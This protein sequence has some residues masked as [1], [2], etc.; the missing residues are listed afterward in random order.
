MSLLQCR[1]LSG[2]RHLSVFGACKTA[3]PI[4]KASLYSRGTCTVRCEN[5]CKTPAEPQ[6]LASHNAAHSSHEAMNSRTPVLI[7]YRYRI[8]IITKYIVHSLQVQNHYR[9]RNS[10]A[11][12][13]W[14]SKASVRLQQTI[15]SVPC[16]H[17]Q[18]S[19]FRSTR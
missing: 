5:P 13:P 8:T 4:E 12:E 19:R 14:E 11:L 2:N 3:P 16:S 1:I 7:V 9:I 18:G 6:E 10:Q 17:R 15:A